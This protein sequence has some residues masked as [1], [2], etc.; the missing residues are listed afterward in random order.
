MEFGW[1]RSRN[2]TGR[3]DAKTT[4]QRPTYSADR[5]AGFKQI[6]AYKLNYLAS[7]IRAGGVYLIKITFV[8]YIHPLLSIYL[9]GGNES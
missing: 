8:L 1:A 7:E 3:G 4:E 5:A 9:I 6:M 2:G